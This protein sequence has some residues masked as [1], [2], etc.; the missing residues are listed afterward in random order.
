MGAGYTVID[1]AL[2]GQFSWKLLLV[3]CSSQDPRHWVV[4][5]QRDSRWDVRSVTLHRGD[6]R[7][8]GG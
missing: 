8:S 1:Q 3:P 7:R 5:S 4:F 2:Y 6:A